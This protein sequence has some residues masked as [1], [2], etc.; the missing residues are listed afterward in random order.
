M[1][2]PATYWGERRSYLLPLLP[3]L[4]ST[5]RR[6]GEIWKY[7]GICFLGPCSWWISIPTSRLKGWSYL[8][9]TRKHIIFVTNDERLQ[10]QLQSTKSYP[11]RYFSH[12]SHLGHRRWH[13]FPPISRVIQFNYCFFLRH[14]PSLTSIWPFTTKRQIVNKWIEGTDDG[15][16]H[17]VAG[18]L[19]GTS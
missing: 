8:S 5:S 3:E 7:I 10:F 6:K 18:I 4:E 15:V 9:K 11:Q 1:L 16:D 12:K 2:H 13:S 17:S 19:S 14:S